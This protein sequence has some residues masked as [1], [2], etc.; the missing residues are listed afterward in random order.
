MVCTPKDHGGLGIHD[1]QVNNTALL[2][3]WLFK[4]LIEDGAWQSL[5]KQKYIGSNALSQF[6]WKPSDLHFWDGLMA[7]K[8][9][10]FRFRHFSIEDGSHIRFWEDR[11]LGNA[12]L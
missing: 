11:E 4:L 9:K 7:T 2:D 12:P 6:Y 5:L 10:F 3:K 1:L 8:T